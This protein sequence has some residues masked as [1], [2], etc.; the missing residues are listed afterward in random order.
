M[1]DHNHDPSEPNPPKPST[2]TLAAEV[3]ATR[4]KVASDVRALKRQLE[5]EKLKERAI[6][7]AERSAESM[8]LQAG[9]RLA[10]FPRA[11]GRASRQHPLAAA[12]IGFGLVMVLWRAS[13]RRRTH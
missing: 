13:T 1:S 8:A 3:G 12:A 5:P 4:A 10:T 9:R 11:L 2:T 7:S 6:V